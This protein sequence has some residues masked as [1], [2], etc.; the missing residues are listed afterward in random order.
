MYCVFYTYLS[1]YYYYYYYYYHHHHHHHRMLYWLFTSWSHV[2]LAVQK[3][4]A[5]ACTM[6]RRVGGND[7]HTQ[8]E[9]IL[10]WNIL[11]PRT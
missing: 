6:S 4:C 5:R 9:I 8:F 1:Y 2:L 3:S 10:C 7:G 11:A